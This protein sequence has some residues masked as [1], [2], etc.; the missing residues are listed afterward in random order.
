[1]TP[2]DVLREIIEEIGGGCPGGKA[3]KD[4]P[5]LGVGGLAADRAAVTV[6]Q[7]FVEKTTDPAG[8]P[9]TRQAASCRGRQPRAAGDEGTF[10][11]KRH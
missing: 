8:L 6:S 11:A 7:Q 3:F 4:R 9:D 1:M 10:L 2:G 5:A